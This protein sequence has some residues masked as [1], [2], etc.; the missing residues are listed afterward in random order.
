MRPMSQEEL[1]RI[2]NEDRQG[3]RRVIW[4]WIYFFAIVGAIDL[5]FIVWNLVKSGLFKGGQ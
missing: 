3:R 1:L 4:R 2:I 5:V